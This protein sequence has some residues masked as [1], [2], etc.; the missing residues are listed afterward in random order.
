MPIFHC[1]HLHE[2][3]LRRQ[4]V[5]RLAQRVHTDARVEHLRHVIV[6]QEHERDGQRRVENLA[7]MLNHLRHFAGCAFRGRRDQ[8]Q[9]GGK[10]EPI[11]EV[12]REVAVLRQGVSDSLNT[13]RRIREVHRHEETP[14]AVAMLGKHHMCPRRI[15]G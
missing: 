5:D 10:A 12:K 15:I 11:V 7:G 14:S 6:I 13:G 1:Q 8:H 3:R 2:V 9:C 4:Q